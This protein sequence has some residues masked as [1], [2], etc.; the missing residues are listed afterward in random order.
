MD[1]TTQTDLCRCFTQPPKTVFSPIIKEA[2]FL[3][4]FVYSCFLLFVF[5]QS[6]LDKTKSLYQVIAISSLPA[7]PATEA[8]DKFEISL[9]R[10]PDM[11]QCMRFPTMWYVRTKLMQLMQ[12]PPPDETHGGVEIGFSC[13]I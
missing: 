4:L 11:S 10:R 12:K 1:Q 13:F 2:L 6:L 7:C 5:F 3:L 8:S 9:V